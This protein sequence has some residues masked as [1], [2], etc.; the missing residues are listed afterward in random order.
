MTWPRPLLVTG[1]HTDGMAGTRVPW[2]DGTY[3]GEG[4]FDSL[5]VTGETGVWRDVVV[6]LRQGDFGQADT[7]VADISGEKTYTV[8]MNWER[9]TGKKQ[10]K[11]AV[12]TDKGQKLYFKSDVK[13]TPVGYLEWISQE[14]ADLKA[15]D[16]DPIAAPP[17][18]YTLQPGRQGK[19]L[20][21]TGAPGLGKST[22][23]QLL[24][25]HHGFVFYEGDCFFG[26]RNPYIPPDVP[27]ASLAQH[28][29]RKLVGKGAEE[30]Q[31]LAN[32][33]TKQFMKRCV[34]FTALN[35]MESAVDC[36]V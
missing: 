19:L 5:L 31:E 20:W 12:V 16:G 15:C 11:L 26:V 23:A 28:K 1:T 27:E 30:R 17:S 29:Q 2:V 4:L 14:E 9:I 22:T 24:S 35:H 36:I 13:T 34:G 32:R 25:R 10:V 33:V 6:T 18:H 3:R 7:E 8:Q 21:I